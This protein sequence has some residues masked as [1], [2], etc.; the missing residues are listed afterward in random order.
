MRAILVRWS[1]LRALTLALVLAL[2]LA[3]AVEAVHHGPGTLAAE[4]DPDAHSGDLDHHHPEAHHDA[5]DHDHVSVA[6]LIDSGADDHTD[7][8]RQDLSGSVGAA[9]SPPDGPRRPPRLTM[10]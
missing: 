3:P 4:A 9:S 1:I 10:I 8:A 6:L 5:S 2:T 7:P